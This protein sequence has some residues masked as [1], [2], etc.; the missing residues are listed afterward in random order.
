L[1]LAFVAGF[2]M[3]RA[4]ARTIAVFVLALCARINGAQTA[5][6]PLPSKDSNAV[7]IPSG[8]IFIMRLETPLHTRSTKKGAK[9]EFHTAADVLVENQVLIPNR[10]LIRAT[11]IKSKRAGLMYGRAEMQI[12]FDEIRLPDG[13]A[14]P[15][16]ATITRAG[17]DPVDSKTGEDPKLKG[18]AGSGADAKSVASAGAQGAIIGILT[19]GP[20]GAMY[21]AAAGVAIAAVGAMLKRGP[22]IDLPRSTMFEARFDKPLEIPAK[23]VLAQNAPG[24]SSQA[25]VAASDTG[26]SE[27]SAKSRPVQK[28]RPDTNPA[29]DPAQQESNAASLPTQVNGTE[30][31]ASSASADSAELETAGRPVLKRPAATNTS[32][33]ST[34]PVPAEPTSEADAKAA[35]SAAGGFKLSVK[36][37]MVQVDAVIRDRS[38]RMIEGL[39]PEDFRV[40]EDNV[41]QE[42]A[43]FSRDELP[44]AVALVVDRSGSVSHYIAELRRIAVQALHNLKPRDQVCLFSFADDVQRLENL[45]EDR[46]RIADAL[47]RIRAEGSTDIM[48]A[49]HAATKYLANTAPDRRHVIILVSDNNQTQQPQVSQAEVITTALETETVIYSLKTSGDPVGIGSQLPSLILGDSVSKVAQETGGEVMKV[50]HVNSLDTA[51]ATVISRLRTRYS[52][53]YYP[54]SAGQGAKFH[55]ISVRLTEKFGKPGSDYSIHAKRGYYA[56]GPRT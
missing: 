53:G 42:V 33:E 19:G 35:E 10:S 11:V 3:R 47:D 18:E 8:Q 20:R 26:V 37:K 7:I 49:L 17:F 34:K 54:S 15:F 5:A 52:L 23:S 51:L 31:N 40:Y 2:Y 43:N 32:A 55:T 21:G 36:V 13:I 25:Q 14:L 30:A 44:L 29:D 12:R 24:A 48:D 38:G 39:H 50:S 45:T 4:A 27:S 46:Q 28:R 6:P 9:V 41:L 16:Q 56:V 1:I 22:D